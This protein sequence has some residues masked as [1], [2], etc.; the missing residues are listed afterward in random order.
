MHEQAQCERDSHGPVSKLPV[1]AHGRVGGGGGGVVV[2]VVGGGVGGL[3]RWETHEGLMPRGVWSVPEHHREPYRGTRGE[4]I[5]GEP[6]SCARGR[7]GGAGI[8]GGW[9][10]WWRQEWLLSR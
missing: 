2:V 7:V 10:R 3:C 6:W 1:T 8:L 5:L 4:E 9:R